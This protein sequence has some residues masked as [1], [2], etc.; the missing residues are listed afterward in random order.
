MIYRNTRDFRRQSKFDKKSTVAQA[1]NPIK[2]HYK[3]EGEENECL[4]INLS[5]R[6]FLTKQKLLPAVSEATSSELG[7]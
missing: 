5:L 7:H 1:G 6:C 3:P 4:A 2:A